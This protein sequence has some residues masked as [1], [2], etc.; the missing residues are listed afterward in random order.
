M[1]QAL[2]IGMRATFVCALVTVGLVVMSGCGPWITQD[3]VLVVEI[4]TQPQ[5]G[6]YVN[7]LTCTFSAVSFYDE[8][9]PTPVD[10]SA[11]IKVQW[12]ANGIAHKTESFSYSSATHDT[13]FYTTSFSAPAGM[14]LD[15]TFKVRITYPG[16]GGQKTLE[17][18]PAICTV[19]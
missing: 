15:K 14:Y 4:E 19:P 3:L 18:S 17:S 11:T 10:A 5:G 16:T 2:R 13:R 8:G 6:T 1:P 12:F 9:V 7:T